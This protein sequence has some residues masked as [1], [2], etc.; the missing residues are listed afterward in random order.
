MMDRESW[1]KKRQLVKNAWRTCRPDEKV[2]RS[3][4]NAEQ[5]GITFLRNLTEGIEVRSHLSGWQLEAREWFILVRVEILDRRVA[6][7][8]SAVLPTQNTSNFTTFDFDV[9]A[10]A[11]AIEGCELEPAPSVEPPFSDD[12][13]RL[14]VQEFSDKVDRIW[15]FAGGFTVSGL[16]T[17][18]IWLIR[19]RIGVPRI[20]PSAVVGVVCTAF[21]YGERELS[22]DLLREYETFLVQRRRVEVVSE[23]T[24]A[25]HAALSE[26]VARLRNLVS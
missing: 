24:R 9:L 6:E 17:L 16:E 10:A 25:I 14:R 1:R 18:S 4:L 8:R 23:E 3:S 5:F 11:A 12:A 20:P 21:V 22:R 15:K 26:D 2:E 13:V 19:R 7:L